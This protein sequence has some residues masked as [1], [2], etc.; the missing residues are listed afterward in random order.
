MEIYKATINNNTDESHMMLNEENETQRNMYMN[1]IPFTPSPRTKKQTVM[2][3][4]VKIVV[5]AV[6]IVVTSVWIWRVALNYE[7]VK[8]SSMRC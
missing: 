5:T 3:T 8:R 7:Q 6:K 2:M 1:T 4:A